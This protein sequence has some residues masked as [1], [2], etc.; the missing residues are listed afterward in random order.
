MKSP[1]MRAPTA[2]AAALRTHTRRAG[3]S[4]GAS[5]GSTAASCCMLG[6]LQHFDDAQRARAAGERLG[7]AEDARD[8]VLGGERERLG[9][10]RDLETACREVADRHDGHGAVPVRAV[11]GVVVER[12]AALLEAALVGEHAL[13]PDDRDRGGLLGMEPAEIDVRGDA[14]FQLEV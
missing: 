2:S 3:G 7:A 11:D 4:A 10:G 6:R 13:A 12:E 14:P 9:G 1:S 8:E 5:G